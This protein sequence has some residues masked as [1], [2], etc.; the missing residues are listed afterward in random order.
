MNPDG[1]LLVDKESK[2]TSHDV[3]DLFRRVTRVKKAGH[4]GTL[5]PLATGLLV[6]CVGRATRLQSYLMK[7]TKTYEGTIRFGWATTT[8]DAEGTAVGEEKEVSIEGLD[9]APLTEKLSG[10]IDQVPPSFSAK[11]VGGVRAYELARR[12]EEVAIEPKRV[13]VDE[14]SILSVDGAVATFRVRC[15]AGTYVRS[16]AHDLG[17][18]TGHGAHLASL[19]RTEIGTFR[20]VDAISTSQMREADRD[21]V[22]SPPHFRPMRASE[23]PLPLV[24]IDP[25]QEKK[26]IRGQSIIVKPQNDPIQANDVVVLS[27]LN[28]ELVAIAE[29]VNILRA[30]GGP[31]ELQPRVVL[32][33]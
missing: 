32:K 12:G 1:L 16:L 5:D 15:S 7:Q 6:L 27:S 3:V 11:K 8:Y 25:M 29:A 10:E 20:V 30:D 28:D 18:M 21:A 14:F 23:I 22:F 13:R 4:T 33:D 19:R 2:M 26:V 17:A 9:F 31:V 24:L